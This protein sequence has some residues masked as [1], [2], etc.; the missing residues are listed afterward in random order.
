[1]HY[2]YIIQCSDNTLYTGY[3]TD[4]KRRIN[5]HNTG[6]GAKYTRGRTPVTLKHVE[7]FQNKSSAMQREYSIKQ[8]KRSEKLKL[9]SDNK[10]YVTIKHTSQ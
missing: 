7:I 8:Q 9:I 2:V 6:N 10:N 5:E 3:T 1:M 4:I